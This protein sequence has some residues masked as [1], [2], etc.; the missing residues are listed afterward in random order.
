MS[1][2]EI[3]ERKPRGLGL[4]WSTRG[5]SNAI[6][7]VLIMNIAYYCTDI[8]GLN[9]GIIGALFAASKVIDAFT[10]LGFGF[11]LDKTSTRFGKARPYEIFI[12]VEWIVTI[13]M[14]NVPK[15]SLTAQYAWVFL[16]YI[17]VNAICQTAL[18]GTDAVYLSR[19]F[20]SSK[21]QIK[22]ISIN[23]FTV[24]FCSIFF[25]IVF[26]MFL[27]GPGKTQA[28]WT[29]LVVPL[30]IFLA[31]FGFLRFIF[32]KEVVQDDLD[33]VNKTTNKVSFKETLKLLSTNK[34]FHIIVLLM[35]L[36]F[37]IN[38]LNTASTYYFK[39]IYGD[40]NAM[41]TA[42]ITSMVVVP[43]LIIFP[44]L[45][46]KFGT[47]M[48]LKVCS[49]IGLVGVL[50]RTVGGPHMSTI[51]LGGLLIGIG[52]LPVAMMIN[53]YLIDCM[54]YGEWKTGVRI[55]GMIAS[56][57]NFASKLGAGIAVGIIGLVMNAVGYDGQAAV[58]N[59]TT[60]MGIVFLYN[61]VPLIAFVLMIILSMFYNVDK[62]RS[63]MEAHLNKGDNRGE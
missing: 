51:I 52:T 40:I 28:G 54:D 18:G 50:I 32:C 12:I 56:I 61:I 3:K 62:T 17:I 5:I 58:Q 31:L 7:V 33:D 20:I 42:A 8:V 36:V 14:F 41:G 39:Y 21:E 46:S 38:N 59:E 11:L 19:V 4:L 15:M 10:D 25:N 35:F 43:A 2:E 49:V 26:P 6:N 55:E 47:T 37:I 27:A 13:M 60:N 34:P 44:K 45:A 24:M 16:M 9:V 63:E 1:K 57:G 48:I 22:A 53:T 29:A 23:G 30:G